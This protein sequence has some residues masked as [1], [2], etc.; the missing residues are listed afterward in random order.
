MVTLASEAA[1]THRFDEKS[2]RLTMA[3]IA[4]R[5]YEDGATVNQAIEEGWKQGIAHAMADGIITRDEE[6]QFSDQLSLGNNTAVSKAMAH[7]DRAPGT[8]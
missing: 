5:S 1:K 8:G 2:L 3:E 4:R 6:A 7:L